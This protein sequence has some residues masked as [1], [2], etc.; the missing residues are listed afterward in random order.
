MTVPEA[1]D[2]I[3]DY[4]TWFPLT[5]SFVDPTAKMSQMANAVLQAQKYYKD[6]LFMTGSFLENHDQPR[7]PSMVKDAAVSCGDRYT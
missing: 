4:P 3:L 2:A 6:G 5:Q 7:L 1:L